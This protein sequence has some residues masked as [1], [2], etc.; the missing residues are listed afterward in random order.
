MKL[1]PELILQSVYIDKII[2]DG[3]ANFLMNVGKHFTVNEWILPFPV[4]VWRL[5]NKVS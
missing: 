4:L 3:H 2:I 1:G 5:L